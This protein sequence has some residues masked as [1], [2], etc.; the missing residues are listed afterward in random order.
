MPGVL[1][2]A[3]LSGL[4]VVATD[5]P[6]VASIVRD[7][8]TGFVVGVDDV[9]AMA[10]AAGRLLEDPELRTA[11]GTAAREHCLTHFSLA[12]VAERWLAL[13]EPLLAEATATLR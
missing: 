1:I 13:L 8:V 12:V 11:M 9:E 3:G 5:V 10:A 4:P 7:G 2:E 6:G